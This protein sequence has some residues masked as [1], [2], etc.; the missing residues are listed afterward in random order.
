MPATGVEACHLASCYAE[1]KQ[2]EGSWIGWS[3]QTHA[4][5]QIYPRAN[6]M[7]RTLLFSLVWSIRIGVSHAVVR[8]KK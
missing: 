1:F 3:I 5:G 2:C 6:D 7:R 4:S 8:K